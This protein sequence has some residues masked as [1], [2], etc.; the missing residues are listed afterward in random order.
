MV[1]RPVACVQRVFGISHDWGPQELRLAGPLFSVSAM[2]LL[3]RNGTTLQESGAF[4]QHSGSPTLGGKGNISKNLIKWTRWRHKEIANRSHP[5]IMR[6]HEPSW[7]QEAG[8][9]LRLRLQPA[10]LQGANLSLLSMARTLEKPTCV[11][12]GKLLKNESFFHIVQPKLKVW[13][14]W[15]ISISFLCDSDYRWYKVWYYVLHDHI[16]VYSKLP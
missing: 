2:V 1:A 7:P 14:L 6:Y 16:H 5:Q 15:G 3:L 10:R 8:D 11:F 9:A 12:F 4:C 13:Y